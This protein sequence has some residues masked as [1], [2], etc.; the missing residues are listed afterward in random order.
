[1]ERLCRLLGRKALEDCSGRQFN[2]RS[3]KDIECGIEIEHIF[4]DSDDYEFP[5]VIVCD[6]QRAGTLVPK[7]EA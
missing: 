1:L 2:L 4:D 5:L 6:I 3:L 7:A